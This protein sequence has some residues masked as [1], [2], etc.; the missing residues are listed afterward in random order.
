MYTYLHKHSDKLWA[1][2]RW[3]YSNEAV[4]LRAKEGQGPKE[5]DILDLN[6]ILNNWI[7]CGGFSNFHR[8]KASYKHAKIIEI[9][10]AVAYGWKTYIP[11][12]TQNELWRSLSSSLKGSH[13][14]Y[15]GINMYAC[16]LCINL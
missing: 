14:T 12:I 3:M 11:R 7:I 6:F 1:W 9:H 13:K 5:E 8:R 15:L 2:H 16:L 10:L 4:L